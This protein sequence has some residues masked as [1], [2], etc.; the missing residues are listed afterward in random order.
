M[1][2][3]FLR[4][5]ETLTLGQH[6]LS[7]N[8]HFHTFD[9]PEGRR[10][11]RLSKRLQ[12]L[13]KDILRCAKEEGTLSLEATSENEWDSSLQIRLQVGKWQRQCSL[14]LSE[15]EILK[16]LPEVE[17]TLLKLHAPLALAARADSCVSESK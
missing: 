4:L 15:F 12:S 2:A 13:G 16:Q 10:A 1:D 17:E 3:F 14:T 5:L 11:L 9:N 7:R 8:R 6:V